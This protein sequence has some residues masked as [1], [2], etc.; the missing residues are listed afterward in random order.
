MLVVEDDSEH[1]Q[2]AANTNNEDTSIQ[3]E[4]DYLYPVLVKVELFI[5]AHLLLLNFNELILIFL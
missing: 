5:A 2:V 3:A 1:Y 4:E